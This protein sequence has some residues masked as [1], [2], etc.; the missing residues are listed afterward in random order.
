DKP[1]HTLLSHDLVD[2]YVG[3]D[4]TH[5]ILHEKLLC[6]RSKF[7]HKIFQSK[8]A[9]ED[10][11]KHQSAS[12]G[13]PDEDDESFAAFVSWLYGGGVRPAREEK[14]LTTLFDLYLMGEKWA[15]GALVADTLGEVREFYAR[16]DSYPGLRRVQYV[17][18]NTD[19][20]SAMRRLLVHSIAR[21]LALRDSIPQHW[22]KALR[23]NG[24]LAVDI[25]RAIQEWRVDAAKV[26][27]PRRDPQAAIPNFKP[28]DVDGEVD[29]AVDEAKGK[30]E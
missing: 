5:W 3:P 19:E 18:A 7:F 24:Q 26:P 6:A 11:K 23:K 22:D 30:L 17:F 27:D 12:F 2:I 28:E 14:D 25:I 15:V 21:M 4:N 1:L 9:K 29:G 16:T 20:G 8:E 13:L 10:H